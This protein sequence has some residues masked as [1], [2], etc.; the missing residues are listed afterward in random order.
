MPFVKKINVF[1][2]KYFITGL[3]VLIPLWAT[4]FVLAGLL[5][6][7]D[8]LLGDLPSYLVGFRF[9]GMGIIALVFFI[10]IVGVLSANYIGHRLLRYGEELMKR[11][12]IVSGIYT[13]I[14]QI[15]ETFSMK[16][17]FQGVGLVEYPRKGCY[18]LGF[19]TGEVAGST[20]GQPGFFVSVF[21]PTTPN[22]TA[23]FLLI[24]PKEEVT[25]LDMSVDEG[26]K[27]II[28]LGLVPLTNGDVQ[29]LKRMKQ[30]AG[31]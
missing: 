28:S 2:K 16:N 17:N 11:V 8:G 15:M 18:S 26:M 13:T 22:P 19:I 20:I 1:L 4:Y 3:L 30:E 9:P 21:I 7:I 27:F 24:L 6:R 5:R 31:A 29:K 23:G 12:P 14:K 25:R 10:L